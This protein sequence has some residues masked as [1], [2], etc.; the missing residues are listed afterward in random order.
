[1]KKQP[2]TESASSVEQAHAKVKAA[3]RNLAMKKALFQKA[4]DESS[5]AELELT[6]LKS[7]H[8]S[9]LRDLR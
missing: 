8:E 3:R 9:S 4:E 5:K 6:D 1:M 2:F 7:K